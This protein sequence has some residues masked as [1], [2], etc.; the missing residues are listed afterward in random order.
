MLIPLGILDYPTGAAG[1]YDLLETQVLTSSAASVTFTGLDTLAAGYSHLQ[2]RIVARND[3]AFNNTYSTY[4]NFNSDTGSN[5]AIHYLDGDGS[6]VISSSGTS[7]G[8]VSIGESV[9]GDTNTAGIYGAAVIDILDFSSS[10][11]NKTVRAL[12]GALGNETNVGLYSGLWMDTSAITSITVDSA[13][14]DY[15]A[16]TRISLYGI[17]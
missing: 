17:R 13:N 6:S 12:T 8:F 4:L 9:A 7:L 11:K 16:G 2:L 3:V 15:I 5:Y 10:S 1:A 14:G